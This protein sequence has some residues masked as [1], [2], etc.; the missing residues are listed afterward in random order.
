M[1]LGF[2]LQDTQFH[3]TI[4]VSGGKYFKPAEFFVPSL[5]AGSA[6]YSVDS[7]VQFDKT[8]SQIINDV[9]LLEKVPDRFTIHI[10]KSLDRA[11][12][13]L[14]DCQTVGFLFSFRHILLTMKPITPL[15][16][17]FSGSGKSSFINSVK[18]VTLND[19]I[20][21][22]QVGGYNAQLTSS[23]DQLDIGKHTLFDT[24]GMVTGY[25]ETSYAGDEVELILTKQMPIGVKWVEMLQFFYNKKTMEFGEAPL[26]FDVVKRYVDSHP[27]NAVF[28]PREINCVL[29]IFKWD[30]LHSEKSIQ[31]M[32]Q[33]SQQFASMNKTVVWAASWVDGRE[34]LA[35]F[36]KLAAKIKFAKVLPLSNFTPKI[37]HHDT[38]KERSI[39]RIMMALEIESRSHRP[40]F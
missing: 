32:E 13:I 37:S 36:E 9:D 5:T 30:T 39:L 2:V 21:V 31:K 25:V 8:L 20:P 10:F 35:E 23:L 22:A 28:S 17:G 34:E 19:P 3:Y 4:K 1:K 40:Q 18:F 14:L 26:T 24:M 15:V 38:F 11:S 12:R 7:Q 27:H 33:L 16:I 29:G 6:N